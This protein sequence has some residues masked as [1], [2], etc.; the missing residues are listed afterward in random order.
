VTAAAPLPAPVRPMLAT[1]APA[2]PRGP[3]WAFEFK[4][5][6]VRAIVAAAGEAVALTS[7]L[8]NDVTAGYPELAEIGMVTGGRPVLL[9]GEIVA[10]DAAGRPNFGLL[11]DRM[12]V[13]HPTPELKDRIPVSFYAFDLLHLD[14]VSLLAAPY[15]ER[16]ARLAELDLSGLGP[17][18]RVLVPPSY[19][20]VDGAQLLEI[21]GGHGLEGVVAKRRRARYEV[22]RRSPAWLK[23]ALSHTQEVLVGGWTA[24]EGRRTGTFGSLLLGAHD[25]DGRLRYLG[26]V[27]TGFRDAVLDDLM[28]RLRPLSRRASPFDEPVPRE[29]ARHAR[30]VEPVLVGEVEYRLITRD[31]RLRHASWRGLRPDRAPDEVVLPAPS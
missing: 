18:G 22:G 12:H 21:A 4:W 26:H 20:D 17:A 30:W 13:R 10:L 6:G 19:A 27:G 3:G 9:D 8:G 11:Q 14:G 29:H 24:G 15:D 25:V 31:G 16:R 5:D 1:A 28:A 23:T 7:R 2:P